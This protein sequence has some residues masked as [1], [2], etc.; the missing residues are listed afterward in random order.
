MALI[1]YNVLTR[2]KE[3]FKPISQDLVTMYV[4]G[5][6]VYDNSHIG[7][8]KLYISMDVI[9]R[10][11]KYLQY[12]VRYVQNIT[13]VGHLLDTGEDRIMKG[14]RRERIEP[15]ELTER[16]TR[17]YFRDMDALG[18]LRPDIS[19]RAS[20]HVPE[21]IEL[22]Q[23]LIEKGHAYEV[24]GSVYFD[25]ASWP[26]YGKLSGRRVNDMEA[27]ARV[28]VLEEKR[29]PSDF[30]LWK[31]A[32]PEHILRWNSPWGPGYPGWHAECTA[33]AAKYLGQ[34]F[35]IHGGGL[36]NMF[37][38]NEC[39]IAQAEAA[40]GCTFA[41]YWLL[42]GS[43]TLDGVK[44]SKSLGNSITIQDA[45]KRWRAQVI[46]AFILSTHY[47]S[48]QDFTD[49][50]IDAIG[51]GWERINKTANLV[52][53]RL[54]NAPEGEMDAEFDEFL[55]AQRASFEEKMDDDFNAPAAMGV[56]HDLTRGVNTL[57][58]PINSDE[59]GAGS[60]VSKGTLKAIETTYKELAGDVLGILA[61]TTETTASPERESGMI[62]LLI[63]LRQKARVN[64]NWQESD[65]IRDR[66]A[67]LGVILEDHPDGTVWQISG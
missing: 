66:L 38:H 14:V 15:M 8:A 57:L 65:R 28:A 20:G 22:A 47:R 61:E 39:E 42:A 1:V 26:E 58:N 29:H 33:M 46:R 50:A 55:A 16:Y 18:V 32:E 63:E 41:N 44:M 56:L 21:Q 36:E 43:L 13:D 53:Q 37:P 45:L 34:P 48:P 31:R 40:C 9:V 25:V 62:E 27:G 60:D 30:A 64:K 35:D 4:C 2:E 19:P 24:N 11:L 51:K 52:R 49:Q 17:N 67:E 59:A 5:P 12:R 3:A 54:A 10:Y 23:T 6:T 7:H